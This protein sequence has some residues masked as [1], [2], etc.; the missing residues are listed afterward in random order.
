MK[1]QNFKSGGRGLKSKFTI[2]CPGH[3]DPSR[4]CF[5]L[6]R[7]DDFVAPRKGF[8]IHPHANMKIISVMQ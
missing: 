4:A 8:G 5:G 2:S 1:A 6:L 7:K 3:C